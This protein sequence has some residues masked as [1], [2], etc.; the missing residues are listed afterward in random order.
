MATDP[1][2]KNP[3]SGYINTKDISI[4]CF[5]IADTPYIPALMNTI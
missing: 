3:D 2:L 5:L 4:L 1:R